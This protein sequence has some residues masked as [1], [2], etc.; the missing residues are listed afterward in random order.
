MK[1]WF[2]LILG[3]AAALGMAAAAHA[4]TISP[5]GVSVSPGSV[6]PGDSVTITVAASNSGGQF[7]GTASFSVVF[8]NIV[9]GTSFTIVANGVSPTG[10][11][12]AAA[13]VDPTTG[14][15]TPGAGSFTFSATVPPQTTQ[16]G[17]Y[18]AEVTMTAITGGA[19]GTPVFTVSASVLTVTG[20]PDLRIT[21]LTYPAG[22]SYKGGDIIPMTLS[23]T[24]VSASS[25]TQNVPFVP[26]TSV[27][28]FRIQV[29]LSTNAAFGDADD[30]ILT[31]F[32]LGA[33]DFT[34]AGF[35]TP[36]ALDADNQLHAVTWN[37]LLPGNYAGSYYVLAKIDQ[38][39]KVDETTSDADLTINGNNVWFDT[40]A[41]RIALQ[42][43]S[44]PTIYLATVTTG[45]VSADKYSDNPS[46]SADGRYTAF[47]SDATNLGTGD[48][49][50]VRDVFLFDN[51]TSL[52]RRLNLS[53]QGAQANG[54][55][56]NP[57]ISGNGRYVAFASDATNLV[58]GDTNGFT[59]IFVVDTITGAISRDSVTS[60]GGQ[61]NGS[62]FRPAI[63]SDG[64]YV[65]F[66]SN[67]T[68]LTSPATSGVTQIFMR[69]RTSGAV[70]LISQSSGTAG[71][72]VS[73]QAAISGDG[74]FVAFASD[75]SNLVA[76]D[77]N[78][79]RDVF[80]RDVTGGTTT[81]V[82]VSSS[83]AEGN[84]PSRAPSIN[85]NPG[86]ASDGRYVAFGSEATNL[87]G[88]DTN[89]VSDIFVR[90]VVGNTTSRVS[91]SSAGAQAVDPTVP[92][93]T[94]AHLG[95]VNPSISATGRYVA[96]ASLADNLTAGD[97]AGRFS[98]TDDNDALDI[99]VNDRDVSGSGTFDTAG[100]IATTMV[101][102]NRFGY[103]TRAVLDQASTPASD[104]YPTI[105]GD[106]RWIAF[107]SD[108]ENAPGLVHGAT[109][110]TSPDSNTFRDIFVYDR[111]INALPNP[112][113]LPTV[114]ISSPL[115]GSNYP[116]NSTI[117]VVAN[118]TT[119]IG[120]VASVQFFANGTPLGGAVTTFPYRTT[121]SPTAMGNYVLSALVTDSF[122][123]Q[124]VSNNV[125][126]TISAISPTSPVV[127]ITSPAPTSSLFVGVPFTIIANASD[128]DGNVTNVQFFANGVSLGNDTSSPF[129]FEFTPTAV[130]AYSLTAVATDNGGNQTTSA[131]IVVNVGNPDPPVVA[132]ISPINGSGITINATQTIR[133][134][135]SSANGTVASVQFFANGAPIG[136]A[137]AAP[138]DVT[139]T[140]TVA[141]TYRLTAVATDNIGT[142]TTSAPVTVLVVSSGG[143]DTVFV[144]SYATSTESGKFAF[145]NV[146]GR[147]GAFIAYST[148][149]VGRVYYIPSVPVDASGQF[150]LV[151]STGRVSIS[152]QTNDTGV[153]GT[154]D[155]GRLTFIGPVVFRTASSSIP[156]GYFSGSLSGRAASSLTAI[157][158]PDGTIT[159]HATDGGSFRDAGSGLVSSTG[160]FSVVT[161]SGNRFT[162]TVDPASGFLTGTLTGG[163]GGA[164]TG[165]LSSGVTFSDGFLRNLSTR[166]QVGTGANILI[167][168]FVV[169]G[170]S[171]KQVLIRA[172]GPSLAP[173]GVTGTLA[174]PQLEIFNGSVRIASN[175]NWTGDAATQTAAGQAGAFPLALG[176][177]D[178]VLLMTLA[179]G[180]YTAQVSGV[181]ARTGVALVEIYDV[182]T[183]TPFSTQKVMN[184]ATRG[185]VGAGQAQLIA[186]FVITGNT[187]KKVLIRGVGPTLGAA[188]FNLPGTLADPV[189]RLVRSDN[190]V[191]RENDNWE[192]G[193]D[194]MLLAQATTSVGAFALPAGSRDAA[195]LINLPPGIY[196]AQLTGSGTTTGVGLIE[197]YE[198][199]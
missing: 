149:P 6:K 126:V 134:T 174:D 26:S 8:T 121:W 145:I 33:T 51:Q 173:F 172:I 192:S 16:A 99:F 71:N 162:G 131:T 104:I 132:I 31:E 69:D 146:R 108:A 15:V 195:I 18:R 193:N 198:V 189:L 34:G 3:I 179:P 151:D 96:F 137:S 75:A 112:A 197:V 120:T 20:T 39:S 186:G 117:T 147:N 138:F 25:G 62:S 144:G 4:Q 165:A 83:G 184:V 50:G 130:G 19:A 188:P 196:T 155:G 150:S 199:P 22:I 191:V 185:V 37:Q 141:G 154:F 53:Q 77:G 140:P 161:P 98:A 76:G 54:A 38:L 87:V 168:G 182:D 61:A 194:T 128:P 42:P 171:P 29:V 44:F 55:S 43:T 157:V 56:S 40:S 101:S 21:S 114:T 183:L 175:D 84:G 100:N 48:T 12:I 52:V 68:N 64:R 143:S 148:S 58:F 57:A 94:G 187:A 27:K 142:Q 63:S 11:L 190:L 119:Q 123:N 122:G 23:Y 176:S 115:T 5:T 91:V 70:V 170:T 46:V 7:N 178:S 30:F 86:N 93:L 129:S 36:G 67:A 156:S 97:Q 109:N 17:N 110:K 177:L 160:A 139:W 10:G 111:R 88:S 66:E 159:I 45:G 136:T 133:A 180:S 14:Q 107:P 82:S 65:A 13:A 2:R 153:S 9:T 125:S 105:S 32:D 1:P 92:I 124:S 80:V 73:L 47:I 49:N 103:Q 135:A 118:A 90:D 24:N 163:P 59:D 152:G 106:G 169:G 74:R 89:A 60:A 78:G 158:A 113:T 81:R 35:P 72:G 127:A 166:G 102:L 181:A 79:V 167:A 85:R 28:S 164:F 41:T 95:S 116:V